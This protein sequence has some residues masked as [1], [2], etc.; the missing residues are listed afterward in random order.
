MGRARVHVVPADSGQAA[1][2]Y[3]QDPAVYGVVP[4]RLG[5][6][7][8]RLVL[9][10]PSNEVDDIVEFV[11]H[12]EFGA[13]FCVG[14]GVVTVTEVE[15][16]GA[17]KLGDGGLSVVGGRIHRRGGGTRPRTLK[18][19]ATTPSHYSSS[20][21][22]SNSLSAPPPS[23]SSYSCDSVNFLMPWSKMRSATPMTG[24]AERFGLL[25]DDA[26]GRR[27]IGEGG[28]RYC[29]GL[30]EEATCCTQASMM[31]ARDIGTEGHGDGTGSGVVCR[32]RRRDG[33]ALLD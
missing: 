19:S 5:V 18:I 1:K 13:L 12:V 29:F 22:F 32:W 7:Y 16:C 31:A 17:R 24:L 20:I 26:E 21:S 14:W 9:L 10:G 27:N 15:S 4:G 2:S 23:S 3:F 25:E 33:D 28:E 8:R 11:A 6:L 30:G